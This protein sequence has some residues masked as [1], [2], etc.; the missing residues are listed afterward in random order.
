[1]GGSN[2]LKK[3]E[4]KL[5]SASKKFD[6]TSKRG[7]ANIGSMATLGAYDP[8]RQAM[9]TDAGRDV[10]AVGTF[11]AAEGS[12]EREGRMEM[13]AAEREQESL[14]EQQKQ[15]AQTEMD[16]RKGR[17][18]KLRQGRRGLLSGSVKGSDR[19]IIG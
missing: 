18:K 14:L 8:A 19:Q 5:K 17:M 13:E 11:G 16:E 9:R 10:A 3:I 12:R 6:P 4:G 2:P 1:M 15:E 7:L